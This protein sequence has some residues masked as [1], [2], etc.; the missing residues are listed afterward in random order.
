M[1]SYKTMSPQERNQELKA[2]ERLYQACH[3]QK[4]S[5]D[6]TRGKPCSEQ[7]DLSKG[8]NTVLGEND[9]HTADGI[10]C[11]NYGG[12]EGIK[13]ARQLFAD[14]LAFDVDELMVLGN[15]SL[16]LMY[17][18][19]TK[20]MLFALPDALRPWKDEKKLKFLCPVPGYDRHFAITE[21]MGFE[22]IPVPMTEDGPDMD[23]VERL[24]QE[25]EAIK[26][27]WLVPVY[28]NPQGYTCSQEV[29]RRLAAMPTAAPDFR[30]F[31]DNAYAVHHL[32][33]DRPDRVPNILQLCAENGHANRVFALASTSKIT[34]AGSG[35]ACLA[36]SEENLAYLRRHLSLQTIGPDKINQLRHVRFLQNAE[37]VHRLM[38]G[39]AKI[40]RPKFDLVERILQEELAGREICRWSK[41][42]G[43]YFISLDVLQGTAGKVVELAK[44]CGVALTPAGS[45]HP[46][47]CDPEDQNIRLA[48]TFPPLGEL[49]Q[50][51]NVLTVCV[52]LA[53]LR[54]LSAEA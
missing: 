38:Q 54:A 34:W 14:L 6:M 2:V 5:L 46:Y 11:R 27:M 7:L 36:S 25:D 39:H 41:P 20:A 47:R 13:E 40:I 28:S 23:E 8:L 49:E 3:A 42:K 52:R 50:A 35:I 48:P 45:T 32:D 21:A 1:L 29:C 9:C 26:G 30:L 16:N 12:L 24:V 51:V 10:D 22:M 53:A 37:G 18:L 4:R 44:G 31:W 33:F 17:D 15:S 43:G 19:I